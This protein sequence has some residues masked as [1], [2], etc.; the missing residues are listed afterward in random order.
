MRH[1]I[2]LRR[3]LQPARRT[4][5]RLHDIRVAYDGKLA[6]RYGTSAEATAWAS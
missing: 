5:P 4:I 6:T 1:A 3:R 2:A